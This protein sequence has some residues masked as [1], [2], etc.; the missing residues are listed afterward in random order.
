MASSIAAA[1]AQ[2]K[3]EPASVLEPS[4]IEEV[5][6]IL[7]HQWRER[8]LDPATT[9]ALF[10]QQV[11]MGN[12]AVAEL[13]RT[14]NGSFSESAY[15]QARMRLPLAVLE[16]LSRRVCKTL[17][18]PGLDYRW[19]GHRTFL[20]DGSSFSMSDTPELRE[21]FG[22]PGGTK[23]GCGFPA[24]HLLVMFDAHTGVLVEHAASKLRTA[25]LT[26]CPDMLECMSAGDIVVGDEHF[27]SWAHIALLI[28]QG[29][30]GL[31]PINH[32]RIVDFTPGRPH[33]TESMKHRFPG[34]VRSPFVKSL[35]TDD[36]LV[37]WPKPATQPPW[38][39]KE[40]YAALP[41][42]ITVRELRRTVQNEGSGKVTLTMVTTLLD[43]TLYSATAITNLRMQRWGVET[44]L[45]HLKTTMKM[46]VLRC[47]TVQGVL[48]EL[49]VYRLVYN[50][51]RAVILEAAKRQEVPVA[52]ISFAD[53]LYWIRHAR[54]G[55]RMPLLK[56]NPDRPNRVEPRAKKRRPKVYDRLNKPRAVMR[57]ALR[58]R[59]RKA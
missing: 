45:A 56:V 59:A 9:V 44:N 34:R 29:K 53:A 15:C 17:A 46:D 25:D 37:Q 28:S 2:F 42:F 14:A 18:I 10:I 8:E 36:Q 23:P 20:V 12:I 39:T 5:C 51:T 41:E 55:D 27:G 57:Q 6:R 40:Q 13:R 24:S 49:E 32:R 21:Y 1:V 43:P 50:L 33:V 16:E 7:G 52:R 48:K 11:C 22:L 30:H 58:D 54:P 19:L 31:F 3:T 26:H 47:Q 35:G 38:L 4:V